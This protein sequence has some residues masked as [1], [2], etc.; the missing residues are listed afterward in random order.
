MG[1]MTE[2][3]KGEGGAILGHI[4]ADVICEWSLTSE[5]IIQSGL[6][7]HRSS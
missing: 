4:L 2:D 7:T 6:S 1:K 3:D 5:I